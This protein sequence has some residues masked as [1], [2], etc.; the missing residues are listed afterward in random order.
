MSSIAKY[1]EKLEQYE[2][3]V[4]SLNSRARSLRERAENEAQ[5][6]Q[7]VFAS[8][9]AA[10]LFGSFESQAAARRQPMATI[11]GLDPLLAYSVG[12]ML[13]GRIVGGRAGE[14]LSEGARGLLAVHSYKIGSR[15]RT[16]AA[17]G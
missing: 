1:E 15:P 10:Y 4:Q 11:A 2:A 9:A 5:F 17:G 8:T 3:K 7:G 16:A 14:L 6:V 13:A 12:G